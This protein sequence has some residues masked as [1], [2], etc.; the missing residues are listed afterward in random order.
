MTSLPGLLRLWWVL[1]VLARAGGDEIVL[2]HPRLP[3]GRLLLRLLPWRWRRRPPR[4]VRLREALESLGP[5]FVKFGQILSTRRDLLPPDIADELVRLQDRV[6]PF[7]GEQARRIIEAAYGQ[8]LTAVLAQFDDVP[9]ASASI[10]Q[11]H[12]GRLPDGREVVIKV[13]RPG[14]APRI[15][16]DIRLLNMLARFAERTLREAR[17]LRPVEVV[18]EFEL[19][20]M[21]ELDLM[22]EAG[23][24]S[25]L[26]RNW[27]N[28]PDLYVPEVYWDYVRPNVMMMERIY[29]IGID[30]IDAMRGAG[31]DFERLAERGVAIFFRQ[32]FEHNF[33]HADM[34]A[35]NIFV[36]PNE[37]YIAVDFGIV[38]S[39]NPADQRYLAENFVAFFNRDYATVAKAHVRAGWVP[40]D[41]RVDQFEAAIRAVCEPIFDKPLKDI[42]FGVLLLR[43]FQVARRFD[44]QVQPQLVLLQKTLLNIEGLG[45]RLYPELDLWRTAKPYLERWMRE[46][47]GWRALRNTLR[48][49]APLWSDTLPRLPNLIH[50]ALERANAPVPPPTTPRKARPRRLQTV[51]GGSALLA[52]AGWLLHLAGVAQPLWLGLPLLLWPLLALAVVLVWPQRD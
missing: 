37:Q 46:R 50:G 52:A 23:N 36:G 17:R 1:F 11:V 48:E 20:L 44:M 26:R 42:S 33:F 5:I 28:S 43:L 4:G 31:V 15:R 3:G 25:Q 34:H 40:P 49:E 47:I 16:R 45:R 18:R 32:V 10:A 19:T 12:A 29:G 21:D 6:P 41:L 27:L 14:I 8:P 2:G 7:P 22:R 9:L 51:L 35:G 39:L 38:G 24:A 13:V 30:N